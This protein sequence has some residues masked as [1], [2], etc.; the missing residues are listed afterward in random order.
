MN[1]HYIKTKKEGYFEITQNSP[2]SS[3][4]VLSEQQDGTT[5]GMRL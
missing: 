5:P 4:L 3:S 1:S 2:L